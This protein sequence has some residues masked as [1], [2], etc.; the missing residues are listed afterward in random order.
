LPTARIFGLFYVAGKR[1]IWGWNSGR[2]QPVDA[3]HY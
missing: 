2:I 1:F 3:T